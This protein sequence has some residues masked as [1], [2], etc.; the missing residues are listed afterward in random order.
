M[1]RNGG[2]DPKLIQR[3]LTDAGVW[4]DLQAEIKGQIEVASGFRSKYLGLDSDQGE[5]NKVT[6]QIEELAV[7]IGTRLQ[8]LGTKSQELIQIVRANLNRR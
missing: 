7:A 6:N 1:L 8:A 5:L 2:Q 3:L 4:I